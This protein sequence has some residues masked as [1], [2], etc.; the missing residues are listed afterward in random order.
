VTDTLTKPGVDRW[1]SVR[2]RQLWRTELRLQPRTLLVTTLVLGAAWA[3]GSRLDTAFERSLLAVATT[4]AL[5][6]VLDDVAAAMTAASPTP[7][8]VR[9]SVRAV[10]AVAVL[11]VP[12]AVIGLAVGPLRGPFA[13]TAPWWADALVWAA[14][15]ASQLALAAVRGG[16]RSGPG[17][18]GPGVI[19]ALAW[20]ALTGAPRIHERLEPVSDHVVPWVVVLAA[21]VAVFLAASSDPCRQ[22][23]AQWPDP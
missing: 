1:P 8:V 3:V 19:L 5:S 4:I 6:T 22:R 9:R 12:W 17:S 18:T 16:G 10:V 11:A 20:I 21:G 13:D 2:T 23:P 14:M 15:A 7:L